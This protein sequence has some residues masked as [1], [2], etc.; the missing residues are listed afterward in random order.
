MSDTPAAPFQVD[1]EALG[2]YHDAMKR[3]RVV[4][5]ERDAILGEL[6]E[7]F[8]QMLLPHN[9]EFVTWGERLNQLGYR[10]QQAINSNEALWNALQDA[11][12]YAAGA[13]ESL[14]TMR[15]MRND[16]ASVAI[17]SADSVTLTP[18]ATVAHDPA[19]TLDAGN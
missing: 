5:T 15:V 10:V 3:A 16:V 8:S 6:R 4:L 13:G 14:P 17:R 19:R 9:E 1:F 11:K 12:K 18:S 7:A 2:R